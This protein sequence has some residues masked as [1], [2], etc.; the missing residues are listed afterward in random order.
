MDKSDRNRL[1]TI[2]YKRAMYKLNKLDVG[3]AIDVIK[4]C[5]ARNGRPAR[6]PGLILRLF[7][8]MNHLGY[9]SI[10]KW[11]ETLNNDRLLQYLIG[12]FETLCVSNHYDFIERLK[13]KVHSRKEFYSKDYFKKPKD[14]PK[15][16]EK[17]INYSH[18]ETYYLL[19]KYKNGA[20]CDKDRKLYKIQSLFNSLVVNPSI[21]KGIIDQN[22]LIL[23]G[24]GTS[25]HI[26]A[27]QYPKK[28]KSEN[29]D[30]EKYRVSVPDANIE[31]D[32]DLGIYYLG[33]ILYNISYHNKYNGID[34]PIYLTLKKASTHD[35][36]TSIEAFAQLLDINKDVHPKYACLDS[37][38]DSLSIYQYFRLNNIISIID[39]N[40]RRKSK[41]NSINEEYINDDGIPV[42]RNSITV[43]PFGYDIQ[44]SRFKYRCPLVMG[45]IDKCPYADECSTS[46][47]GRVIYINDGD[48]I[49][50]GGPISYKSDKWI[51]IYKNRT[52]TERINNRI[53]NDYMV[54]CQ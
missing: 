35:A 53:L 24:D 40:N 46:S 7:I 29:V 22:E 44:R 16:G 49:R 50:N 28:V 3:L 47:Y 36:I 33:Y 18:S 10:H 2:T 21:D 42:C 27:S 20:E 11:C 12:S 37:A 4:S 39:H 19:D 54:L 30:E 51:N 45:K 23:S 17:L 14:K 52:S 15:K 38:G 1:N 41:N 25:L 13:G 9:T 43:H 5:Y 26:H 32:S 31:W 6:D 34:L 8:L 48:D